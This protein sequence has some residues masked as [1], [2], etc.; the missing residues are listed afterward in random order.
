MKQTIALRW[1][2]VVVVVVG[3]ACTSIPE[4]E[5]AVAPARKDV[6]AAPSPAPPPKPKPAPAPE[7]KE[8]EAAA[9]APKGA[10]EL[11]AA[12]R[13]Y[14]DGDYKSAERQFQA[15]LDQGLPT[16]LDQATA[17]K[18]LAFMACVSKRTTACRA[19]FRKAFAADPL[20]DLTPAEAGHPTWGPVFRSV[21]AEVAKLRKKK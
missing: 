5:A 8:P 13:S 11:R 2:P 19:E 1:W 4:K 12:L 10:D 20:F 18:H 17:R 3:T 6:V 15:A 9:P 14:E 16:A 7:P 21:K